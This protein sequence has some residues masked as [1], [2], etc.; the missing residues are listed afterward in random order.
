MIELA[1][2]YQHFV[3]L[4]IF[5]ET[6]SVV[7]K[8]LL[9]KTTGISKI[10]LGKLPAFFVS[11]SWCLTLYKYILK[12]F[13][14]TQVRTIYIQL[15]TSTR[16]TLQNAVD[17]RVDIVKEKLI[18]TRKWKKCFLFFRNKNQTI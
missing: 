6:N 13:I 16:R 7:L 2:Y 10:F 14:E 5:V 12:L 17:F 1:N 4:L 9:T 3:R 15:V 11:L 18:F 8:K